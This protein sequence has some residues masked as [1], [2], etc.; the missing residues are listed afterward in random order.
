MRSHETRPHKNLRRIIRR[1][2]E[3]RPQ[4]NLMRSHDTR[5][6]K[7]LRKSHKTRPNNHGNTSNQ[8]SYDHLDHK[9]H[10]LTFLVL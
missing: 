2:H 10:I 3:T 9:L 8:E 7:D 6:Q 5:P 4:K 1:S